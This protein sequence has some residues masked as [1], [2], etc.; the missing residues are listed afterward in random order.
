MANP[1]FCDSGADCCCQKREE[2]ATRRDFIVLAAEAM[3]GVGAV[4]AAW[5]LI[6][7]MNPAVATAKALATEDIDLAAI[8]EG[9][10]LTVMW[11]G[12]PVFI[13][14]RTAEEIAAARAVPL[15]QLKDPQSD[16]DRVAQSAFDGHALPQWLV[17]IGK[18][19]HLGC[20]PR[21]RKAEGWLCSCHGAHY[22]TSGRIRQGPAPRN[23]E[24]P[25]YRFTALTKLRIG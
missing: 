13:R 5:P 12:K 23:L 24:I 8:K 11:Q 10:T 1:P 6:D 15:D 21:S 3:A 22:D 25:P 16:E 20:I 17:L 19:T 14:H 4:G 18:C 9:Q 7:S 2:D